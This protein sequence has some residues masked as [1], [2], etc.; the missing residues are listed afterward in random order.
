[1]TK[2]F[3]KRSI[4]AGIIF[5]AAFAITPYRASAWGEKGHNAVAIIAQKHLT[6]HTM[7]EVRRLLGGY[8][9]AYYAAW[10][11]GIRD[12]HAYDAVRTWHYANVNEGQTYASMEKNPDG[13]V[14]TAVEL[15]TQ[16]LGDPAQSDSLKALNLK[17]LIHFTGDLHCPMH[18]GRLTDLGGND[19]KL[20]F[21]G[22]NI[23]L[24]LLWDSELIDAAHTWS[25]PEWAENIDR[26]MCREEH[27]AIAAGTPREWFGQS[28][29]LARDIYANT[30]EGE[31]LSYWGYPN[32][33]SP[34][35]ETQ[36][37]R[38][39]YRLAAI[40]NGIFDPGG[41]K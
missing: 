17:L 35:I 1:M 41:Q 30:P 27:L 2:Y 32:H 19:V 16:R 37:R 31:T 24:H 11:D 20:S 15:C 38:A 8:N 28:V 40:L 9:M 13:D 7:R 4:I 18:A 3:M 23:N 5:A 12:D 33:Y 36:L 6:P 14:V 25:A 39:G 29:E 34:M 21:R 22:R 26:E 10:A